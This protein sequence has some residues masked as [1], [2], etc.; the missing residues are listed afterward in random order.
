M[1]KAREIAIK[2]LNEVHEEGAY[3]N[4]ALARHL[5]KAELSDQD[6]R[7]VT[8]LVYGAVKA[9]D[10]LDWIL[11]RY[12]NRPLKKIPTMVREILRLGL[13][14]IFYLDKVP[15][16]A[17]CNTAVELAKKYSHAGT[18]KFVNA[19]LR[20]A[21]REPEKAAFPEGKGKA[22]EGLALKSQHPYWLVKRWVKQFGFEEAEKLCAFDNGQPVLSVRTNTLKTD[23]AALLTALQ[24]AGAEVQESQWTPEGI[25][26]TSHGALDDLAPL[27]EG[28]CQVQDE[29]SMLVAHVV[30]PQPG[31]LIIDC[32]SAPGGK[33]THMAALMKNEGRIVAGDIYE[34][35]LTRIEENAQRLGIDI[36]ETNLIDAREIGEEYEDMADRVLVDAPCSGLGVLRRKPDARWNKSAEEIAALPPLQG[37]ILDSAAKALKAGGVLVYSTCTIDRSENDEVVEAFLARHP[38]FTLE[39]TGAFLPHKREDMMVQLYPQRDG[40]DGFF[41]AR[42]RKAKG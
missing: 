20:T 19:V 14:Q 25:R 18:V 42:M 38:E 10:T 5:R 35:K 13:Y 3:A 33:T 6:R 41:I 9:G 32:C 15:A 2:I 21:V 17:A 24:E 16:S 37:E 30:D 12:V 11:R 7:F 23:R 4:V 40:T 28:L 8:E 36:I 1:D 27:Q 26:V 29:S 39:Q 31:E 34:H 22:T